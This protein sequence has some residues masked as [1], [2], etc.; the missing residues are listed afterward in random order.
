MKTIRAIFYEFGVTKVEQTTR[1]DTQAA[2][3]R[4]EKG[5]ARIVNLVDQGDVIMLI[6]AFEP[7]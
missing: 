6:M 7:F 3:D 4:F 2:I 1:R 5:G